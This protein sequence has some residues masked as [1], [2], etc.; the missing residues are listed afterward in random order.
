MTAE[1]MA[2]LAAQED[3]AMVAQLE[4]ESF[5]VLAKMLLDKV[6]LFISRCFGS[7]RGIELLSHD[8]MEKQFSRYAAD[9][10]LTVPDAFAAR[11][12]RLKTMIGDFRDKQIA[13]DQNLRV[14]RGTGI[15]SNNRAIMIASALYPKPTDVQAESKTL[16][17]L[18]TEIDEWRCPV[19][20]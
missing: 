2:M 10:S 15:D 6:A 11:L 12:Q 18:M 8:R 17:D 9:K 14:M 1:Q 3:R 7:A 19:L 5:Y 4:I 20:C 16:H 13:H